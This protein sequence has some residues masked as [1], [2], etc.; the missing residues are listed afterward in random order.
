[1]IF[2]SHFRKSRLILVMMLISEHYDI[3][4]EAYDK[5]I[6]KQE[7]LKPVTVSLKDNSI[8]AYVPRKFAWIERLQIREIIEDL[9]KYDIIKE[10]CSPYCSRIVPV[11][12]RNGNLRL[13][14]DLRLLN[15]R[16]VKQKYLFSVIEDCLSWLVNKSIFTLLDL[17]ESFHAIP[18][19]PKFTKY[20]SFA[21]PD[22][23]YTRKYVKLPF[24]YSESPAEFQKRLLCVLGPLIRRDEVLIYVDNILIPTEPWMKI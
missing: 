5:P 4:K 16:I 2:P 21:T 7:K 10:S 6:E 8:F 12:K 22:G 19:S 3:I 23:Q 18:I 15:D 14:V 24:G 1:M 11:R 13:C 17:K 20:F 9:L